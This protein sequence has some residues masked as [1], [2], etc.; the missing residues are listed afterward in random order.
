[1]VGNHMIERYGYHALEILQVGGGRPCVY[2]VVYRPGC[3][4]AAQNPLP[5]DSVLDQDQ[6]GL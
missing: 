4:S 2:H 3:H 1:M 6:S 5:I